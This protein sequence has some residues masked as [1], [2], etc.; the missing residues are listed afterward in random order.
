MYNLVL[1]AILAAASQGLIACDNKDGISG[2]DLP[3]MRTGFTISNTAAIDQ[4]IERAKERYEIAVKLKITPTI[5]NSVPTELFILSGFTAE[6][7][8]NLDMA[9]CYIRLGSTLRSLDLIPKNRSLA[10]S[11]LINSGI[12]YATESLNFYKVKDGSIEDTNYHVDLQI[13]AAQSYYWAACNE[14]NP[15]KKGILKGVSL[16]YFEGATAEAQSINDEA[17]QEYWLC[18]IKKEKKKLD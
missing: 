14:D 18:K 11:A 15:L 17:Q 16:K 10:V 4:A 9:G 5:R 12:F 3:K 6:D 2:S 7:Q 8:S 13:S 1:V